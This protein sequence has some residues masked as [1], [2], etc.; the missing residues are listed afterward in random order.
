MKISISVE[1]QE[2]SWIFAIKDNGIGIDTAYSDKIFRLF[3]RLHNY[4]NYKGT[5][6]GLAIC[7][8]IVEKY[9]GKIWLDKK[10]SVG[11][12]FYFNLPVSKQNYTFLEAV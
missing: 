3:S 7:Q 6:I 2:K 4:N 12:T 8:K 1:L 11:C 10:Q 9:G 5:G